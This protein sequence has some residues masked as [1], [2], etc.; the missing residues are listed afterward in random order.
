MWDVGVYT[1]VHV[2]LERDGAALAP[3]D[4]QTFVERC[5]DAEL[6]AG[7]C[8]LTVPREPTLGPVERLRHRLTGWWPFEGLGERGIQSFPHAPGPASRE[9]ERRWTGEGVDVVP[10][11]GSLGSAPFLLT[12]E[13]ARWRG[14]PIDGVAF[15]A[16]REPVTVR[17][18][19]AYSAQPHPFA[20]PEIGSFCDVLTLTSRG[21][22]DGRSLASSGLVRG[23]KKDLGL[24]VTCR[25]SHH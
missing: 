23:L 20:D 6:F 14:E 16:L 18:F 5:V 22:I 1:T 13:T 24:R 21:S 25:A 10:Q 8:I 12:T 3:S 7:R 11:L 15:V 17:T 4:R 2:C 9:F 19:D